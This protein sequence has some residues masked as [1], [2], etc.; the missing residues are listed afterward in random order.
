MIA[1]AALRYQVIRML[2]EEVILSLRQS[3]ELPRSFEISS[4]SQMTQMMQSSSHLISLMRSC[5]N[6]ITILPRTL[7]K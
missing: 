2:I 7:R 6:R 4:L 1:L 5:N 3:L